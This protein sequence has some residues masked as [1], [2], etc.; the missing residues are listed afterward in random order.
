MTLS[1]RHVIAL[2]CLAVARRAAAEAAP[3]QIYA[4][5]TFRR[6]LDTVLDAYRVGGGFAVAVYGPTPLL[7]RQIEAGAPADL[8][9]SAD[10][11]WADPDWMDQAQKLGLV[12]AATR[13]DLLANAL[14]LAG[15]ARFPSIG[16][17]GPGFDLATLLGAGRLAMCDPDH[18]P[19]GRYAKQSLQ[20]LGLWP[21]AAPRI[22]LAETSV[23]AV[24]LLDRG[25]V[26]AAIAFATDLHGDAH[27]AAIGEFPAASHAP[28]VYPVALTQAN[29]TPGAAQALA[30]LRSPKAFGV[31]KDFGYRAPGA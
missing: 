31:F 9:L 29:S 14:V 21:V 4:A 7:V 23:A 13:T 12:R 15:P 16:E 10:P 17:I 19:A 5:M 28:I 25:E 8:F 24:T 27:A 26:P 22:A 18:D 30:F 2:G 20:A 6:A 3:L 11:D 1:R